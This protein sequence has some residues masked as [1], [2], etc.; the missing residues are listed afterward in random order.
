MLLNNGFVAVSGS[1]ICTANID[2][3]AETVGS[4]VLIQLIGGR[5]WMGGISYVDK[6]NITNAF[7]IKSTN[8]FSIKFFVFFIEISFTE[9][10]RTVLNHEAQ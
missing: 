4:L 1:R 10:S 2:L 7:C 5:K 8:L 3:C 9:H 6:K